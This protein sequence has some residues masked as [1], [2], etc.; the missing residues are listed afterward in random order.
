MKTPSILFLFVSLSCALNSFGITTFSVSNNNDSGPGSLRQALIDANATA[1]V[2]G[3][4]I[5]EFS[6]AG[7]GNITITLSSDLPSP[8]ES[9]TIDG[10][11]SAGYAA[12]NPSI[13]INGFT[14]GIIINNAGAN[15]SIIRGLVIWSTTQDGIE[16]S[17]VSNITI[18]G[19]EIGIDF[20]GLQPAAGA[21]HVQDH[22]INITTSS[23]NNIVG[24]SNS[25]DRNVIAGCDD[26]G[27]QIFSLSTGNSIRG[28]YIGLGADGSTSI[29]NGF[30]GILV[31]NS[32]STTIGGGTNMG[33]VI[34]SNGSNGI[35]VENV[36]PNLLVSSNIIGMASDG[37]TAKGN[38]S[39]GVNINN[40]ASPVIGGTSTADRNIIS[41]NTS[42]GLVLSNGCHNAIIQGNYVGVDIT[43]LLNRGNSDMGV[44]IELSN[45]AIVGGETALERN[46]IA[47]NGSVGGENELT[48]FTSNNNTIKGNFLGVGADGTTAIPGSDTGLSMNISSG[49]TIGGSNFMARN[50]MSGNANFGMWLNNVDNS[51]IEGNYVGLDSTGVGSEGNTNDGISIQGGSDGDTIRG[52]IIGHNSQRGIDMNAV[53]NTT[54]E[55]NIIGMDTTGIT[56]AANG[57]TGI[58]M[59]TSSNNNIIQNNYTGFNTNGIEVIDSDN[60]L[61]YGNYVGL[62]KDGTSL[63]GNTTHGFRTGLGSLNN[64]YGGAASGQRN[65]VSNNGFHGIFFDGGSSSHTVKGN[66][67]GCD[68]S[69]L[70]AKG[71][72]DSGVFML[73]ES[74]NVTI[75]GSAAGE[76][77]LICCSSTENGIR[78]QISRNLSVK[79]NLIGV[80]KNG[81]I[82][83]G[84]GNNQE[85]ILLMSYA[86]L[87]ASANSTP[88]G[89]TTAAEANIIAGNGADGIRLVSFGGTTNF[90]PIRLNSI[91]CNG[92]LGINID[93]SGGTVNESLAAPNISASNTNDVNGT[94]TAGNT[95]HIYTNNTAD[96]DVD[97]NCEGETYVGSTTVAGGGTWSYTHN[98]GLIASQANSVSATQT[99]PNSSTSEFYACS[100]PLPVE[101]G[102]F[103]ATIIDQ[104]IKLD[105]GT[106][107]EL[108]NDHFIIERSEDAE[109]F[110]PI[111]LIMGNG[112]SRETNLYSFDDRPLEFNGTYYYRIKQV[113][114]SG[115]YSYSDIKAISLN[116]N[117]VDIW[118][119]PSSGHFNIGI[120]GSTLFSE[121]HIINQFG[122]VV[123]SENLISSRETEVII[124]L[125]N[126]PIGCYVAEFRGKKGILR[127]KLFIEK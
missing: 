15:G 123:Y 31:A 55:D 82:S 122:S 68:T 13:G 40:S 16:L 34:S 7:A 67:V 26:H 56:A 41:S 29:G 118:P 17:G 73:D 8:T 59:E 108:N 48:F 23:T 70:I 12:N 77:N 35:Q 66:Y 71:N 95:I 78:A 25:A 51:L 3:N 33:N 115:K 5:I 46:I 112:N 116:K 50:V 87:S 94:G 37:S 42:S 69:G 80:N 107:L 44:Y 22:G 81:E 85:G 100:A 21:D 104:S 91:Y 24:G 92:G 111:G 114:Y 126:L 110:F 101:Y 96:G 93:E 53:N 39:I 86:F 99:N 38:G 119:N 79:G 127:Q 74:D 6:G 63:A 9:V 124:N 97:C 106:V 20:T 58:Y 88:I 32:S 76:G 75:G 10:Y 43:G 102:F 84:F 90:I 47:G 4:D 65:Y 49:N 60:N 2:G 83:A 27:I 61:F 54:I 103:T 125:S 64:T 36:S 117:S 28:N 121:F 11:T 19:C 72:A 45:S 120:Y 52:N 1:N 57:N 14:H 18:T 109:H 89:G 62:A 105:W 113:D 30:Y 98:L